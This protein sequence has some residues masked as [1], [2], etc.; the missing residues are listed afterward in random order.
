MTRILVTGAA[1]FIGSHTAELLCNRGHDVLAV[2]NFT[3]GRMENLQHFRG[4]IVPGDVTDIKVLDP[5]MYDFR[6]DAVLHLAAQSAITTSMQAPY[7]D[8]KVNGLGVLN[9]I[10]VCKTHKVKRLVFSSTSAV[11]RETTPLFNM[12]IKENAKL[13]PQSPYGISKRVGEEYIRLL[14]PNHLIVRFGNVY[15]PRQKPIGDNLVIARALDHFI[16]GAEFWINGH[17]NQKRDFVYVEDVAHCCMEALTGKA[18]GTFN[19]S[20]GKSYSV[21]EVLREIE[22]YFGVKGYKWTHKGKPDPRNYVGLNVNAIR[23]KLGWKAFTPLSEGVQKT[24]KW[25]EDGK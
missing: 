4:R 10:K 9:I 15:G 7:Y 19:V 8:L 24:I 3:T 20:A 6:P 17:G 2:D 13:E 18:V 5:I 21:N 14:F 22:I 25:W 23:E 16:H 1:G 12:G 11:Y